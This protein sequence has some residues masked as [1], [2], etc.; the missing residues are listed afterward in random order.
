MLNFRSTKTGNFTHITAIC[1]NITAICI[2]IMAVCI[3]SWAVYIHTA[4]VCIQIAIKCFPVATIYMPII[5]VCINTV[6]RFI[7]M[8]VVSIRRIVMCTQFLVICMDIGPGSV[9]ILNSPMHKNQ[10]EGWLMLLL[11]VVSNWQLWFLGTACTPLQPIHQ[12]AG[13]TVAG[14]Y[15]LLG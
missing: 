8:G 11:I 9:M 13:K 1:V 12:P 7:N 15:V 5:V 4:I 2:K 10:P 6:S 14:C 3:Q